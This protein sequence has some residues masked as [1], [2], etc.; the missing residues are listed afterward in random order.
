MERAKRRRMPTP[1]SCP[2][3][4][5]YLDLLRAGRP[6]RKFITLPDHR[7]LCRAA[8]TNPAQIER[9]L[10]GLEQLKTNEGIVPGRLAVGRAAASHF[11]RDRLSELGDS[12]RL[13][14]LVE[15]NG[16]L[17]LNQMGLKEVKEPSLAG[18][19]ATIK[20][21]AKELAKRDELADLVLFRAVMAARMELYT[22][23]EAKSA[24]KKAGNE[25]EYQEL[26]KEIEAFGE[27]LGGL[28]TLFPF[29]QISY[30]TMLREQLTLARDMAGQN[31]NVAAD[32]VLC[33]LTKK[34]L[35]IMDN[36]ESNRLRASLNRQRQL[37]V[38][39]A[40]GKVRVTNTKYG[41]CIITSQGYKNSA[42][43]V[44][45][46]TMVEHRVPA[47]K[48]LRM[49]GHER[50]QVMAERAK[51]IGL[52]AELRAVL[53]GLPEQEY[54]LQS[55]AADLARV[56]DLGKQKAQAELWAALELA[57]IPTGQSRA[58]ARQMVDAAVGDLEQRNRVL[59][60]QQDSLLAL[61]EKTRLLIDEIVIGLSKRA[62][63]YF[64][65]PPKV[66]IDR[67]VVVRK[68]LGIYLGTLFGPTKEDLK[69]DWQR[70]CRAHVSGAVRIMDSLLLQLRKGV[71]NKNPE[72][73]CIK[74][75]RLMLQIEFDYVNRGKTF[76]V[77]ERKT[78][79][80]AF[81]REK[82]RDYPKIAF[83]SASG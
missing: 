24:A 32:L 33:P 82:A 50:D 29:G 67:L 52:I 49:I 23:G 62:A 83:P 78:A 35:E 36:H 7:H 69:E 71:G 55:V 65:R 60:C 11:N 17:D 43:E 80:A 51:N 10:V 12:A 81:Y 20:R 39:V 56:L 63:G 22:L 76:A 46:R 38:R 26:R 66:N 14:T 30:R 13:R 25:T 75:A 72:T 64:A 61:Q 34:L 79:L 47:A 16:C 27:K 15:V 31:N 3:V 53:T 28:I 4:R 44:L 37:G 8:D 42:A 77:G 21:A 74:A 48:I 2:N 40:G 5:F 45:H 41:T 9:I 18:E 68:R 54:R 57:R 59:I 73:E 70:Q 1:T 19:I 6:L 58:L